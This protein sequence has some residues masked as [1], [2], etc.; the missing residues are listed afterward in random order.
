MLRGPEVVL[1]PHEQREAI[2]ASLPLVTAHATEITGRF[3]ERLFGAHPQL[4]NLF[5][6]GNQAS[7]EQKQALAGAVYAYAKHGG[8]PDALGPLL[9]RVAHKHASL[10]VAPEMYTIVGEH[11]MGAI[12]EVLGTELTEDV[13]ESWRSV[14]WRF[15]HELMAREAAL[16]RDSGTTPRRFLREYRIVERV[17]EG[18]IAHSLRLRPTDGRPPPSFRPGQY[19]SVEV[20]VPEMGLRQLRQYSLS[21]AADGE[22]L[23]ITVK[24]E[25]A[26]GQRPH[27]LVSTH[28]L[29]HAGIGTRWRL[30]AP[31]GDLALDVDVETPVVMISA[32]VGVTPMMAMRNHLV[33]RQPRRKGMF[34]HVAAHGGKH[35]LKRELTH[36]DNVA[37][38]VVYDAAREDDRLGVDFHF[39]GRF[40][41]SDH[42]RTILLADADHYLCGP[43]PFMLAQRDALLRLGVR[44]RRVH[45]EVFGPDLMTAGLAAATG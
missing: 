14:Y 26:Q 21:D 20:D 30:S 4:R 22:T 10:G 42:A 27:G 44:P 5:N 41:V 35:I 15:A 9:R 33:R 12:A 7:G 18:E 40:S 23:R 31:C 29:R 13:A 34:A 24:P 3:Y 16:Y 45:F 11:L 2:R 17:A 28:L 8:D 37:H 6:L 43:L 1:L 19:V 32:G 25:L 36:A 38:L 39:A